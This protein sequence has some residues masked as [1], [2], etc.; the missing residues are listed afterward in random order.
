MVLPLLLAAG[1]Q[2]AGSIIGGVLGSNAADKAKDYQEGAAQQ[3]QHARERSANQVQQLQ[4]PGVAAYGAGLNAL[5]ARLGLPTQGVASAGPKQVI[6]GFDPSYYA[7]ARP[8]VVAEFHRLSP[9]NLKNNLGINP[10]DLNAFL[11]WHWNQSG[12]YEP[13]NAPNAAT[14]EAW[15]AAASAPPPQA[16]AEPAAAPQTPS[17]ALNGSFGNTEDPTWTPPPAFSFDINDFKDN[18]AYKFALDQ[19]SGQVMANAS[20]TGALNSGAALKRLQDRGQQT[21]YGFYDDERDFAYGKYG[22]DWNRSRSTYESDRNYLTDRYDQETSDLFRYTGVGQTA[23]NTTTN[24]IN[25]LGAAE[26]AGLENLGDVRAG[27]AIANGNIWGGVVNNLAGAAGSLIS[28][29]GGSKAGVV[30]KSKAQR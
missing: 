28:G 21:A 2:A 9:N 29:M 19:G 12:Q 10:G 25:G 16:A 22:D 17:N 20:V 13:D 3:A 18:P 11:N 26:S 27:A 8:D 14:A 1:A 6:G 23:L 5:T 15:R 4:A 24:S 7:Q 30:N